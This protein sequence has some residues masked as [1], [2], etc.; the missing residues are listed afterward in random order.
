M[1]K[2]MRE[3]FNIFIVQLNGEA[4]LHADKLI[5]SS[6]LGLKL[7]AIYNLAYIV[8]AR[9]NDI[10]FL[11]ASLHFPELN[12]LV[13]ES[14]I[15]E[16]KKNLHS[17]FVYTFLLGFIF[18][19]LFNLFGDSLLKVWLGSPELELFTITQLLLIGAFIG[20]VSWSSSNFLISTSHEGYVAKVTTI[21]T[22][23][24]VSLCWVLTKHHGITGAA[25]SWT[26]GY[27]FLAGLVAMRARL[28]YV[29]LRQC[30]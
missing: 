26:L 17:A 2:V 14:N 12:R 21:S 23:F 5:I 28:E 8:T 13:N 29:K 1:K 20:L 22:V 27:A 3:A 6:I 4:A 25:V 9:M 10:G 15:D 16:I 18:L 24:S 19:L 30:A 11:I 7:L